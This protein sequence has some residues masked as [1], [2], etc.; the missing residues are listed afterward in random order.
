M[1]CGPINFS[2]FSTDFFIYMYI[3]YCLLCEECFF[4][5]R[6]I[7]FVFFFNSDLGFICAF[8]AQLNSYHNWL[9]EWMIESILTHSD[10]V[11]CYRLWSPY[12][13]EMLHSILARK[14]CGW[15]R[16]LWPV[17][18]Y[19]QHFTNFIPGYGPYELRQ[20]KHILLHPFIMHFKWDCHCYSVMLF[21]TWKTKLGS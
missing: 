5:F 8:Q 2:F 11:C 7:M 6:V 14:L 4:F 18:H 21:I 20:P 16:K 19:F 9:L 17:C 3:F 10:C 12:L 1:S 15:S 13:W